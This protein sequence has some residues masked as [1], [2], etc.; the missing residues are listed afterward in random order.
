M[1]HFKIPENDVIFR[2][3]LRAKNLSFEQ[4]IRR[5]K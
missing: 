2:E 1:K 4:E 5:P 3:N